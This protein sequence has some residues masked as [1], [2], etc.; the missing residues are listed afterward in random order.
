M[1]AQILGLD[2]GFYWDIIYEGIMGTNSHLD[3]LSFG[4]D[5]NENCLTKSISL[6]K[7]S[8]FFRKRVEL[9]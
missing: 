7:C 6:T 1:N 5:A 3:T 4:P 8:L 9:S 2:C